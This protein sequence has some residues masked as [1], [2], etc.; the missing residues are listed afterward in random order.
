MN[1]IRMP[2]SVRG[3]TDADL[4]SCGGYGSPPRCANA[5]QQI[6]RAEAAVIDMRKELT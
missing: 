4:P 6:R 5:P 2:L 1:G 3:L